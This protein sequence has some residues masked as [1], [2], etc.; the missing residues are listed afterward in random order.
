LDKKPQIAIC[1]VFH[2]QGNIYADVISHL[3]SISESSFIR[4]VFVLDTG[5]RRNP[6]PD[7]AM[8]C[9]PN[10]ELFLY[11]SS[12]NLGYAAGN[13]KLFRLALSITRPIDLLLV[14]NPD[15]YIDASVLCSLRELHISLP[16]AFAVAPLTSAGRDASSVSLDQVVAKYK[17]IRFLSTPCCLT[18]VNE[19]PCLNTTFLPGSF[20]MFKQYLLASSGLFD[21]AFFMYLEETELVYR[22]YS[23]GFES[24]ISLSD[25]SMHNEGQ[26]TTHPRKA[27]YMTR[28]SF[29]FARKLNPVG[30]PCF[31]SGRLIK[32]FFVKGLSFLVSGSY[33]NILAS[34]HGFISGVFFHTGRNDNYHQG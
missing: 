22:M 18:Y 17:R 13:N 4:Y 25:F 29:L 8:P 19:K 32:P 20:I 2:E 33:K 31:I 23:R 6:I 27:Y 7:S 12:E 21:E 5:S 11:R 26:P 3:V 15:V 1:L 34:L 10:L 14:C 24:Y 9:S 28:N 30:L 16:G